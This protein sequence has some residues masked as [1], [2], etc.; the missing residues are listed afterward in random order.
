M[1]VNKLREFDSFQRQIFNYIKDY[2]PHLMENK[3]ELEEIIIR[4]A[5][6]AE[7]AYIKSIKNGDPHYEAQSEANAIL[8]EGLEFSPIEY[9]KILYEENHKKEITNA[10]AIEIYNKTK[11]IFFKYGQD[12]EGTELEENLIEELIP[13]M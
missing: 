11:D 13:F 6:N 5:N 10:T 9:I 12:F 4:R 3:E 1:S 2:H 7:E 8:H